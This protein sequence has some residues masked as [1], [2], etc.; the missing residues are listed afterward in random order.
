MYEVGIEYDLESNNGRVYY[1]GIMVCEIHLAGDNLKDVKEGAR[2]RDEFLRRGVRG[3]IKVEQKDWEKTELTMEDVK[4]IKFS[5][6]EADV[7]E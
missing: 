6:G 1:R 2:K 4:H 3:E 5:R 7:S